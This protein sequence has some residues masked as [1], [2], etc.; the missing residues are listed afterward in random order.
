MLLNLESSIVV[1]ELELAM[2]RAFYGLLW[3]LG[4]QYILES[5]S[6]SSL[7][8]VCVTTMV[9]NYRLFIC[10]I[11]QFVGFSATKLLLKRINIVKH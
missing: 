1:Q 4:D 3:S 2:T 8:S 9:K 6:W 7:I 11:L 5:L 10:R